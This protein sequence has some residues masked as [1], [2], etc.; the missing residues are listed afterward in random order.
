MEWVV[1]EEKTLE[2]GE[3]KS[4]NMNS[5]FWRETLSL[6]SKTLHYICKCV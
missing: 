5:R 1:L 2:V 3:N 4:L 6:S